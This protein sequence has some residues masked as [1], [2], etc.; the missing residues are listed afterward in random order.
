MNDTM[1]SPPPQPSSSIYYPNG[2]GCFGRHF[3]V[4]TNVTVDICQYLQFHTNTVRMDSVHSRVPLS[5]SEQSM[6]HSFRSLALPYP[7]SAQNA[8]I[9]I[10]SSICASGRTPSIPTPNI[11]TLP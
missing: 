1:Q 5:H 10:T 4:A 8:D 7:T 11:F 2:C 3:T 9:S 6:E